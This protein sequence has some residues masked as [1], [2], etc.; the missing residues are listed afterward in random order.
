MSAREPN[1]AYLLIGLL[2]LLLAGPLCFEIF[3]DSFDKAGGLIISTAFSFTL[4]IGIWSLHESRLWFFIGIALA[5]ISI[6]ATIAEIIIPGPEYHFQFVDLS[7]GLAFC[8]LTLNMAIRHI[9]RTER[10]DLNRILGAVCIYLLLGIT[11]AIF[12]MFIHG[13]SPGSFNNVGTVADSKTGIDLIYYTFVT[14]TTLGYGDIEPIRPL[15]RA[16]AYIT[17]VTGQFYIAILVGGVVG[18]YIKDRD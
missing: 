4:L 18:L 10:I 16:V 2:A 17:A 14:I 15:A 9:V 3:G 8:I 12:N 5:L 13:L 11:L 6:A 1:Y 7:V